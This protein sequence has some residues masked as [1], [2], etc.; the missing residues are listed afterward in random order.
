MFFFKYL[1]YETISCVFKYLPVVVSQVEIKIVKIYILLIKSEPSA[2][3]A[4]F[5]MLIILLTN[6]KGFIFLS[7][8]FLIIC[9]FYV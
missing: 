7:F 9:Q 1:L 4:L 5:I 2:L 3:K 8:W 6:V